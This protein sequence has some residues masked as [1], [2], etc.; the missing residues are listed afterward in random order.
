MVFLALTKEGL[1]EA[2]SLASQ[3]KCAIWC[4]NTAITEQEFAAING[5]ALTR[6]DYS[7]SLS[8]SQALADALSTIREHHPG[9][10]VWVEG[11]YEL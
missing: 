2:L 6:F 1:R 9:D 7:F 10:K 4:T 3:L 8:D 5:Q 11:I